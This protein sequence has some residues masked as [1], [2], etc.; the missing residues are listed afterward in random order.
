MIAFLLRTATAT[1]DAAV[2]AREFGWVVY[3]SLKSR[4]HR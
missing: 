2:A 3:L 1:H 4:S